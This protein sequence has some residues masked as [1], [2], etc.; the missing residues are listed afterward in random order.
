M[1]KRNC[2]RILPKIEH[3]DET[4]EQ[5]KTRPAV[6]RERARLGMCNL[7]QRRRVEEPREQRK[8]RLVVDRDSE[9]RRRVEE[10]PEQRKT[11]L[12]AERESKKGGVSRKYQSNAKPD[13]MLKEKVK[14]EGLSRNYQSNAKPD[15]MLKEKVKNEGVLRNYQRNTKPGLQLNREGQS[16]NLTILSVYAPIRDAPDHLKD[17][18][19]ADLQLTMNKIP[20]KDILVIG[21]DFNARIGTRLND[22]EW[23][24]GNH[25]LGKRCIN[26]VRL[27][28][29]AMLNNLSAANTWFK[30][31]PCNT[32]TWRSRDG[33]PAPKL[34]IYSFLV[35][36]SQ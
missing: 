23:A 26:G 4:L 1:S 33:R 7:R 34:T 10:L 16:Y 6:H 5:R 8:T 19:Y 20:R 28:M 13:L 2:P 29:F 12:D 27:L 22:S 21:G 3:Q 31:K 32:Y 9:K 25:G 35:A 18:F 15:L 11:I 17:K 14:E 36:G 30:H 24:I